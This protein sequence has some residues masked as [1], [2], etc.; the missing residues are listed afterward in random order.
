LTLG[1]AAADGLYYRT[2]ADFHAEADARD[3]DALE[4]IKRVEIAADHAKMIRDCLT[5]G[6]SARRKG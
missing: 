2:M 3:G 4:W 6:S 1:Y 5:R